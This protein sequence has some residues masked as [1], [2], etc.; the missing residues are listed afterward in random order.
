M[1]SLFEDEAGE[2]AQLA[3]RQFERL[4]KELAP[5]VV[6]LDAL[7]PTLFATIARGS[8][9]NAAALVAY[10]VAMRLQLPAASLPPSLASVYRTTLRL[11]RA[12]VLAISQSGE[13][14]DLNLALEHAKAGGACTL[15]LINQTGSALS[16]AADLA[17]EIG[18]GP[19]LATAA[20]KSFVLSVTAGLHLVAAWARDA[21]LLEELRRFPQTL[22]K[23]PLAGWDAALDLLAGAQDAFVVGRGPTLPVAQEIALK[24][25]EVSGL[26]AEAVS[27]AELLHGPVSIAA[28]GRPAIVLAGDRQSRPSLEEAVKRL[29]DA[30]AP[31]LVLS[32]ADGLCR[33]VAHGWSSAV[34]GALEPLAAL[35]AVYPFI[36]ALGRARGRDPD[37]PPHLMKITRTL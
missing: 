24:L 2:I 19:E 30:G 21:A 35:H 17:L 32:S 36:A 8:S 20:T 16:R 23:K 22:E 11:E 37:R 27:A 6:R 28:P 12:C 29:S 4:S 9:D 26:H 25:K 7:A 3:V 18:A 34:G 1:A 15:A 14:P 31:V 13:S 5:V 10:L 33:L